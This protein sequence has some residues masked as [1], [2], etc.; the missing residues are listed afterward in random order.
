MM[1]MLM[2]VMP[3]VQFAIE[4][5]LLTASL[6]QPEDP[7]EPESDDGEWDWH[8]DAALAR[9]ALPKSLHSVLRCLSVGGSFVAVASE[10][11]HHD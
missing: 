2:V 5:S 4:H 1:M 11:D 8:L 6:A 3:L 9:E 10:L 7:A